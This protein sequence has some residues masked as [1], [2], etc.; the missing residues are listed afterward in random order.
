[1]EPTI[2]YVAWAKLKEIRPV[3]VDRFTEKSVWL[4]H[5]PRGQEWRKRMSVIG[6]YF[7]SWTE[8][9][10]WLINHHEEKI[11]SAKRNFDRACLRLEDVL[12]IP[13]QEP[14]S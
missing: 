2:M 1:M 8:A 5:A 10:E 13:E 12:S 11:A 4:Y 3:T 6:G 9:R 14:E 7:E